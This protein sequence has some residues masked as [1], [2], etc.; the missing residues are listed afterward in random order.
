MKHLKNIVTLMLLLLTLTATAQTDIQ[1]LGCRRGTPRVTQS[2]HLRSASIS[3]TK[4]TGGD[5]Y[6]GDLKQLTV[7]VSFNDLQFQDDE[8]TTMTKWDK[9]F[10]QEN[11]QE[12][13]YVGSVH[14]YFYAQS[15]GQMNLTFDLQY[16]QLSNDHALYASSAVVDENSQFLIQDI[17]D[18][19]ETR[20]I[21][22]S[23][24]DWDDDG[25]VNQLLV[26][27]AGKGQNDGGS[28]STIWAH[29]WWM[30]EHIDPATKEYCSPLSIT[31]KTTGKE[32]LI[33][34]Y[35]AVP[36]LGGK[37]TFGTICHEYTHC[38]G[39]PD[40][41]Y[42][43]YKFT[44]DWELMDYGNYNNKGYCPP[45]YS[46]HERWLMGWL[47]PTELSGPTTITK[48][49]ALSNS[50]SSEPR[51]YLIRND[52]Y[53]NEY[54]IVENRQQTGWD[55]S[56]PGSGVLIFHVDFDADLWCS[57]LGVVNTPD[58]PHY[59]LFYANNS[60]SFSAGWSYPYNGNNQLT[61][62]STP[63]AYLN[64]ENSDGTLLMNKSL[65]DIEV[66]DGL[67]SFSFG[68]NYI[69]FPEFLNKVT[70]YHGTKSFLLPAGVTA[71]V[72]TGMTDDGK[73]VCEKIVDETLLNSILPA[74][75]PVILTREDTTLPIN[76]PIMEVQSDEEY[77]GLNLLQGSDEDCTTDIYGSNYLFY[78]LALGHSGT[79]YEDVYSWYWGAADGGAF[80]IDAH[81]AWLALP[82]TEAASRL[83]MIEWNQ[84]TGL[85]EIG[86]GKLGTDKGIFYDLSGHRVFNPTKGIYILNGKKII[87]R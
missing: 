42:G 61:N 10:N 84:S 40:F 33:D 29:Q 47:T 76:I 64:H 59:T 9:I 85:R 32:Y 44:K 4:K 21:D 2:G 1:Q 30:S 58:Y 36:E 60:S 72:V 70:F 7:L 3:Q 16:V 63:A 17:M 13:P 71:S 15:D 53:S 11:Y 69:H 73:L 38:F 23:Q 28:S 68:E 26:I 86:K 49:P 48:M 82:M 83:S 79:I 87:I 65:T 34:C 80:A 77:S 50:S 19:L 43:N 27:F 8:A 81:K 37:A 52:G 51:A 67:A 24:Y 18:E 39:F 56:L 46:A 31:N 25:F 5:F 62:T 54:Y 12:D 74:N 75:T 6:K 41:Y 20:D 78:K 35:C 14:D 45:N 22:W 66:T 55:T 57:A